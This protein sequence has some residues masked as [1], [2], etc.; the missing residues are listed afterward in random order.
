VIPLQIN[1]L[2]LKQY[3]LAIHPTLQK[4]FIRQWI[5]LDNDSYP[6]YKNLESL[7]EKLQLLE[8]KLV[9]NILSMA[10]GLG[11]K[12]EEQVICKILN[13]QKTQLIPIKGY[14]YVAFDVIF[15]TNVFLPP[16]IG[17]GKSVSLG[18]GVIYKG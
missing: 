4:Y 18:M 16:H 14:K 5:A 17:L 1:Q 11:W 10:K 13:I 3:T 2:E 8:S 12:I 6:I 15:N 9:G 7:A